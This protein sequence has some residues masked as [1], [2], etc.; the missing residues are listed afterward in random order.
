M[1]IAKI[2]SSFCDDTAVALVQDDKKVLSSRRFADRE[3]QRRLGGISP[4]EA[5][6]QHKEHLPRLLGECLQESGL[7]VSDVDAIAVTTKPGLVIALKEGIRKGLELSRLYK[8]DFISIHH[9]RAHALSAFLVCDSLSFPFISML[10]SG[11]HALIVLAR[12]ASDFT[13][14]GKYCEST[15]GSP[16]EC[17]DK[18]ARELRISE[19]KEFLDVHPGAAVEQLAS[20]SSPNGHLRYSVIGP[21]TSG[22][23]MNFSQLKSSYLNLARKHSTEEGFSIEDFCASVQHHVTRHIVSKLHNCLE[24]LRVSG[25]LPDIKHIVIS[26]GVAANGYICNGISKLANLHGL[27]VVKVPPRLCTDN[28]EMVAWN[29]I[30]CLMENSA[31]VHRYPEIP[32]SVYAHARFPIDCTCRETRIVVAAAPGFHLHD[33]PVD[34]IAVGGQW[35]RAIRTIRRVSWRGAHTLQRSTRPRLRQVGKSAF[36]SCVSCVFHAVSRLPMSLPL[37]KTPKLGEVSNGRISASA[38]FKGNEWRIGRFPTCS[39]YPS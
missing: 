28:A 12:S 2:T 4:R 14:F 36:I 15:S 20:R 25:Q 16:G 37:R 31:D 1:L 7:S 24:Y 23:D 26:G 8:K 13:I 34:A 17:L 32:E 11:G 22:A 33:A 21:H 38:A 29:G 10:I 27:E 5:A 39:R 3:T 18:I 30:L 6:L 9:M 19:M 35:M